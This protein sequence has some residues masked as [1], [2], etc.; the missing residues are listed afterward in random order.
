MERDK[1]NT[2][3]QWVGRRGGAQSC[4]LKES[5]IN[6]SSKSQPLQFISTACPLGLFF[7]VAWQV[8]IA[9]STKWSVEGNMNQNTVKMDLTI[10]H[11]L[12][13]LYLSLK[14]LQQL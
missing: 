10:V 8:I 3:G 9:F 11:I 7:A 12:K 2:K 4:L 5:M 14:H 13:S 1:Q 6:S